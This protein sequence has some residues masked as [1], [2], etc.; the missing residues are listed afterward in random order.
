[1]TSS[2]QHPDRAQRHRRGPIVTLLAT[3]LSLSLVA[4]ACGGSDDGGGDGAAN[5]NEK[6]AGDPVYGGKLT[7][8]IEG[9][10]SGGAGGFCLPEAQLAISG[11]LVSR[12]FYDTLTIPNDEGGYSPWLAESVTSDAA[13]TTWTI[14]LRDGISFHDGSKLDATVVK[15]NLDAFRG[16]YPARSPLLFV[17]VLDN[18]DTVTATDPLTV[19][20]TTKKPWPAFPAFLWSSGRFA[21]SAQ[22]QLDSANCGAEIIGT[23]P[24]VYQSYTP[25]VSV[26]G[27]KNPNYWKKDDAG[28]QLP[29]LDELTLK[30]VT[31]ASQ[32]VIGLESG[33]LDILHTS[34]GKA[35]TSIRGFQEAGTK[36][37]VES[38]RFGEVSY[39]LLN[40][41]KPPFNNRNARLAAAYALN[42]DE[43][44]NINMDGNAKAASGPFTEGNMGYLADTGY[45]TFD[46]AKARE[47]IAAYKAETG[48]ELAFDIGHTPDSDVTEL[49]KLVQE[50]AAAVG[51]KV[52]LI[53]VEQGQLINTA[54]GGNFQALLWRN[55]PGGDPDTQY[56]WWHSGSPTN[57]GRIA[58][59]ELDRLLEAGRGETDPA[60]RETIYQDLNK[61]FASEVHNLWTWWTAWAIGYDT[62]VHGIFGPKLDDGKSPSTGL[63]TGHSLAGLWKDG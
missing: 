54:L 16:K 20:V 46:Q 24:F 21:I 35:I 14:K 25:S 27:T 49:A 23:G 10:P 41:S 26:V 18:I 62:K 53:G 17:F 19:T 50:Q 29:Y 63:A 32:R 15:N 30:V 38:N 51:V 48:A 3:L 28:R 47:Y 8:G 52:N 7:Y 55:H 12:M 44:I 4:A 9:D 42:R 59:P 5:N 58:D 33:D 39:G 13:A 31:E 1:M 2:R 11:I 45:P 61:R 56:V 40:E 6:P 37:I 43:L 34:D 22:K 36:Q 57:F 60:K